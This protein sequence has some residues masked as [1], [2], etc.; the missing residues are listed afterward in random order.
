MAQQFG[1]DSMPETAENVAELLKI[2]RE[3][4]DS[5]ALRSQQQQ[6]RNFIEMKIVPPVEKQKGVATEHKYTSICARKR[7]WNSY[8][9]KALFA[10]QWISFCGTPP[11]N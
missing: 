11:V 8:V 10:K 6:Q 4:Q 9:T 5:F 3:D 7:R 1:T 2:S